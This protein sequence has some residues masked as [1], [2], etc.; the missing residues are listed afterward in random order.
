M[1]M[2]FSKKELKRDNR[3]LIE[4]NERLT[5]SCVEKQ[6]LIDQMNTDID[7]ANKQYQAWIEFV[8]NKHPEL[9]EEFKS[10][11]KKKPNHW[12]S[13]RDEDDYF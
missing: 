12:H 6:I 2:P 5:A 11:H 10:Y 7:K 4:L 13:F 8:N 1:K 9:W 3:K